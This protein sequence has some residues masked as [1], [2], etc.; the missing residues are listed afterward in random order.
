MIFFIGY[1]PA[2]FLQNIATNLLKNNDFATSVCLSIDMSSYQENLKIK[3][4]LFTIGNKIK[5]KFQK[6]LFF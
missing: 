4:A 5:I 6:K 3:Y 2:Y 1:N